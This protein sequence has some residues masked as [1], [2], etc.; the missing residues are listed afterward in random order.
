MGLAMLAAVGPL[1]AQAPDL[2]TPERTV[3][4]FLAAIERADGAALAACFS[5]SA[6]GEFADVRAQ[7]LDADDWREWQD[8][9]RGATLGEVRTGVSPGV[10]HASLKLRERDETLHLVRERDGWRITGF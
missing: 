10:A 1:A 7:R 4:A 5:D 2:S 3:Q 9:F 8:L 6:E